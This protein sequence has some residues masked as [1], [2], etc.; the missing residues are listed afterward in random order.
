MKH[1]NWGQIIGYISVVQCFGASIGYGI[2]TDYRRMLYYYF[3]ALITLTVVW[4]GAM[5]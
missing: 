4:P 5:K 3:A 1:W 2:A